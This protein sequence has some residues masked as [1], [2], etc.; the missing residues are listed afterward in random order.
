MF[1]RCAVEYRDPTTGD[2][3]YA[4][5]KVAKGTTSE[6]VLTSTNRAYA[7]IPVAIDSCF[8]FD[9]LVKTVEGDD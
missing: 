5:K 9:R 6:Y 7:P 2:L 8:P 1:S 4:L 3:C